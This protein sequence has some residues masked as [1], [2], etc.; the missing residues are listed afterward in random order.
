VVRGQQAPVT[1]M[2]HLGVRDNIRVQVLDQLRE[3]DEVVTDEA[4]RHAGAQTPA[5]AS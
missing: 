4:P 2:V 1:L 3:G 5:A